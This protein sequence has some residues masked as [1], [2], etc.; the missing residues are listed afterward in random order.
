M[1]RQGD[2]TQKPA[3]LLTIYHPAQSA[4]IAESQIL[5]ETGNSPVSKVLGNVYKP[6]PITLET[7][8]EFMASA[9]T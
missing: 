8:D 7:S 5:S 3:S 1:P 9:R 6:S 4:T 2:E